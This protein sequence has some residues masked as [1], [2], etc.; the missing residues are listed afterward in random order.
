MCLDEL[1]HRESRMNQGVVAH[2]T[3]Y[4][5]CLNAELSSVQS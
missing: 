5:L 4:R 1:I 3:Y 2:I